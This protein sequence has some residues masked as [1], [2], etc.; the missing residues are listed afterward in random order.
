[1]FAEFPDIEGDESQLLEAEDEVMQLKVQKALYT[2]DEQESNARHRETPHIFHEIAVV[3]SRL[4][5]DEQEFRDKCHALS[6]EASQGFK[7]ILVVTSVILCMIRY[8]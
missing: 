3:K 7:G 5:F 8:C 4:D 1:M 6:L 2:N